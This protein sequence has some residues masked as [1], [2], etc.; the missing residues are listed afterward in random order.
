MKY[1]SIKELT[2]TH[3]PYKNI[4]NDEQLANLTRLICV[5]DKIRDGWGSPIRVNSGFRS[6]EVNKAVGGVSN[7]A[8]LT[9]NAADLYPINGDFEGFKEYMIKFVKNIS[10][11]QCIIERNSRGSIWIHFGLFR[12]NGEQR[13]KV[14]SLN[15]K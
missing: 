15:A 3:Q 10:F 4:P 8:H 2:A 1:F 6:P 5:L 13:G 14:F 7:S 11:D 12:N 9:G